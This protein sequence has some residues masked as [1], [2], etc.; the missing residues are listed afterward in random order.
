MFNMI[1]LG[2]WQYERKY[3][4]F[5]FESGSMPSWKGFIFIS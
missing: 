5:T 4:S 1:L 3:F 2:I